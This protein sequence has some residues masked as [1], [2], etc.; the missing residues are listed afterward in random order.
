VAAAA[1]ALRPKQVKHLV[2]PRQ[3]FDIVGLPMA[4]LMAFRF[5]NAYERWWTSRL[6]V[7]E[8]ASGVVFLASTACFCLPTEENP[9]SLICGCTGESINEAKMLR[10]RLFALFEAYLGFVERKIHCSEFKLQ[11]DDASVTWRQPE[12]ALQAWPQAVAGTAAAADPIVWCNAAMLECILRLEG[13]GVVTGDWASSMY[14]MLWTLE[15]NV[16]QCTM[17]V[18][19]SSPVPF[20]VHMRTLLLLFCFT[21]PFSIMDKVR[22][23]SIVLMQTGISFAFLGSEF[24]SREMEHPFGSDKGDIPMRCVFHTARMRVQQAR[25]QAR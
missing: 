19:Q 13:L 24:C 22:P 16:G 17:V 8:I 9:V 5:Q 25:D 23:P 11:E 2:I 7:E 10:L 18:T 12:E 3:I 4:I 20:V 6:C 14:S 15:K 1:A 21:F